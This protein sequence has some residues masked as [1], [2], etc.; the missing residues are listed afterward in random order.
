RRLDADAAGALSFDMDTSSD[1]APEPGVSGVA[2]SRETKHP[3]PRNL[4]Q[5]L[6][7]VHDGFA[8][9][10]RDLVVRPTEGRNDSGPLGTRDDIEAQTG[11]RHQEVERTMPVRCAGKVTSVVERS[12]TSPASGVYSS[13]MQ[14]AEYWGL[15]VA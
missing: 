6:R 10:V 2:R 8:E 7:V 15:S 5:I 12:P 4:R 9:I 3:S 14:V 11:P 1:L 13:R